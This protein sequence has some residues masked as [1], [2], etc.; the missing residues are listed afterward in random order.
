M[1]VLLF[2]RNL[3]VF[4]L[5]LFTIIVVNALCAN[6]S[7]NMV[8]NDMSPINKKFISDDD[9]FTFVKEFENESEISLMKD[10]NIFNSM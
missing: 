10:S 4:F 5:F 1:I 6:D 3:R 2:P 7:S 8:K 9:L